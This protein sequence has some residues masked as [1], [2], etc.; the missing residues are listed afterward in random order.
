MPVQKGKKIKA[1]VKTEVD[2]VTKTPVIVPSIFA[3]G[4]TE[5]GAIDYIGEKIRMHR[6][7]NK[8]VAWTEE[9]LYIRHQLIINWLSTGRST[10]DVARDIRNLWGVV[11]STSNLYIKEA[12]EYLTAASDKYRDKAREVQLARLE[13]Y[14]EECRLMGKYLEASKFADQIAKLTGTYQDNK[15][16][17]IKSDKPISITFG[18]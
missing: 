1:P 15:K 9:D 18:E 3:G 2:A 6:E 8:K 11:D 17:E 14:M 12:L 10:V 13:R 16:L 7:M 4:M 5:Q